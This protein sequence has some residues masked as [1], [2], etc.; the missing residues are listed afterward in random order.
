MSRGAHGWQLVKKIT[1]NS[2]EAKELISL[3]HFQVWV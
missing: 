3:P 2:H 1:E